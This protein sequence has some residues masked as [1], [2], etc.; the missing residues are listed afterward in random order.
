MCP[1]KVLRARCYL[2]TLPGAG[3]D[4]GSRKVGEGGSPGQAGVAVGASVLWTF[5]AF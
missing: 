1:G 4:R 5:Q 2:P 3:E